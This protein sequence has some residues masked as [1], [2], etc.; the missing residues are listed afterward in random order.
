MVM[1]HGGSNNEGGGGNDEGDNAD[2]D[3]KDDGRDDSNDKDNTD[4]EDDDDVKGKFLQSNLVAF[5][6]FLMLIYRFLVQSY[7]NNL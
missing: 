6:Q 5:P 7:A 3:A 4:F 1:T 2:G